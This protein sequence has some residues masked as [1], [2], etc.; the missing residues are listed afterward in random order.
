MEAADQAMVLLT[1][2]FVK[3][4]HSKAVE[5]RYQRP[6]VVGSALRVDSHGTK[7]KLHITRS[8][9]SVKKRRIE[10]PTVSILL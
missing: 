10:S 3:I 6:R 7:G 2:L 8:E 9:Q 5:V 4:V 1:L